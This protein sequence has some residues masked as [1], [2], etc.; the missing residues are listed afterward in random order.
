MSVLSGFRCRVWLDLGGHGCGEEGRDGLK[1][2][3][4][5]G[6]FSLLLLVIEEA[7]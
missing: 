4:C 1:S 7:S 2:F 5:Y 3:L 6:M